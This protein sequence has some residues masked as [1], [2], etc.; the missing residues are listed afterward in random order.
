MIR[1]FAIL[2]PLSLWA[3]SPAA[4]QDRLPAGLSDEELA[5]ILITAARETMQEELTELAATLLAPGKKAKPGWE[6]TGVDIL[7]ELALREGG[8]AGNLLVDTDLEVRTV[9]DLSGQTAPQPAGFVRYVLRPEP[10]DGIAERAYTSFAKGFWF[11]SSMQ[12]QQRG[13][14]LC[15][16][17]DFGVELYARSPYTEWDVEDIGTVAIGLALFETFR[18]EEICVV[19]DRDRQGRYTEKAYL[20]DGRM[21]AAVNAQMT[22]ALV[23]PA[24]EL[25]RF[26]ETATPSD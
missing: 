4:A 2:L 18:N 1:L 14:A 13:N 25:E 3:A 19:Y 10:A 24:N 21:L 15:Y 22:P 23:M 17:G 11:A 16:S 12:R 20:P 7:A 8:I 26:L 9:G 5:E 6:K